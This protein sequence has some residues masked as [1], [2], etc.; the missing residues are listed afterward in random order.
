MWKGIIVALVVL[1][2]MEGLSWYAIKIS[3]TEV[4][5]EPKTEEATQKPIADSTPAQEEVIEVESEPAKET[6]TSAS[7]T[8]G[9]MSSEYPKITTEVV[10]GRTERTIHM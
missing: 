3:K 9:G 10:N 5:E 1:G 2:L 7:E 6:E 8:S 4:K